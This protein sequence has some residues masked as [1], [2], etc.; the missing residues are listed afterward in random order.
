MEDSQNTA[1]DAPTML[2]NSKLGSTGAKPDTQ[3]VTKR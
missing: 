3:S 1:P 2:E